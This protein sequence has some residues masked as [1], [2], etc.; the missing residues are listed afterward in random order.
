MN[1]KPRI[2]LVWLP[3]AAEPL[4]VDR[5]QR[6]HSVFE[7]PCTTDPVGHLATLAPDLLLVC[8]PVGPAQALARHL[9]AGFASLAWTVWDPRDDFAGLPAV[10]AQSLAARLAES[11]AESVHP[12][13]SSLVGSSPRMAEVRRLLD[14]FARL[15]DPVLLTG[16]SGSGKEVAARALHRASLRADGPFVAVNCSA[17]AENLFES[18]FFGCERGAFTD[19]VSRPG[20]LEAAWG[21]TLFLDELGEMALPHQAKLLRALEEGE[22]RRVGGRQPVKTNFRLVCA[23]NARLQQAVREGRFRKDLYFRVNVLTV[24]LPGLNERREDIPALVSALSARHSPGWNGRFTPEALDC[25]LQ[26]DWTGNVRELANISRRA[27]VLAGSGP[28]SP[29]HLAFD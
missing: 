21:G 26:H 20:Y 29:A 14:R 28:V 1:L 27:V 9:T 17:V 5:L 4:L 7:V 13:F 10:L 2:L 6:S 15:T 19:A 24:A 12:A 22:V 11:P 18:E 23:T 3:G 8:G 25:L 16:D